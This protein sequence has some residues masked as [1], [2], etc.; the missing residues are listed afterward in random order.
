M[1][2]TQPLLLVFILTI[3]I[4]LIRLRKCSGVFLPALGVLGLFTFSLPALDWLFSCPLEARYPVKPFSGGPADAIVVLSGAVA[5]PQYE[6][7]YSVPD[8]DTY[9]RCLFAAWLHKHWSPVPV[10]ASGGPGTSGAPFSDTMQ[11]ILEQAGV[12]PSM[13]WTEG[14]SHSTHENAVYSAM[15]LRGKG[16]KRIVLVTESQSMLRAELC[17]Q[18]EGLIVIPAPSEFREVG[19]LKDELMPSWHAIRRNEGML[20]ES[21]GLLWYWFHGWI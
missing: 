5:P 2:Y 10:L 8:R 14:Q 6:T 20:H 18:K 21:L 4:G 3:A 9:V 17:F 11:T 15:L 16:I 7:P 19:L 1:T 12:P 13:I